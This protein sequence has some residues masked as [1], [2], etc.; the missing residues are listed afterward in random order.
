[1]KQHTAKA[2]AT[3]RHGFFGRD[4]GVSDGI[5]SSLNCGYGS[6]DAREAIHE[7]R[8]RVAGA[9][10]AAHDDL[11]TL[12]QVHSANV[13]EV[14]ETWD[15]LHPPKADAVVTTTRGIALAVLAA[16]CAPIL[17]ADAKAGVVGA[18][19]AGWKGALD[20]VAQATVEAMV[21]L[22]AERG[23]IAAAVGPCIAQPSY[24]VGPEFR[25]RFLTVDPGHGQW[26][27]AGQDGRF[28]FDLTGFV[29][30]RL[31]VTGI[32]AVERLDIDTY[33]EKNRQFSYRR[34]THRDEAGY[35]RAISAIVLD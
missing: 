15:V 32:G 14:T 2:L 7:N 31:D 23:N 21:A 17:F 12:Y 4:G 9:M 30:S 8:T 16:D 18:A 26:F 11:L 5:Y 19:H 10:G 1:M 33:P 29:A 28:Q 27:I 13:V 25:E 34:A 24:E 35:G 20:G 22:G 3:V 6:S